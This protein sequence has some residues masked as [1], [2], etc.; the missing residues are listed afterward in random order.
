MSHHVRLAA[1]LVLGI[2]SLAFAQTEPPTIAVVGVGVAEAAPDTF[3]VSAEI[4]GRGR[5]QVAAIRALAAA[6]DRLSEAARL[7]GLERARLTTGRPSVRPTFEPTCGQSEYGRE[8]DDCPIVGYVA[9]TEITLEGS[10]TARAGDALSLLSERGA[11]NAALASF[12]IRDMDAHRRA[13]QRAAFEDARRQAQ[14]LADASGRSGVR[15]VK[16]EDAAARDMRPLVERAREVQEVVVTGSRI[17][18][19]VAL[20]VAPEPVRTESRVVATF[21][22]E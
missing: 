1:L 7:D 5:D 9:S 16:L 12:L 2:P 6:Q 8:T 4:E 13:A 18:P 22:M 20:D 19:T 15:L 17:R 10:P 11:R 21:A 3:V 14:T